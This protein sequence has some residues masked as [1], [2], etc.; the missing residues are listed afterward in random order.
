MEVAWLEDA[1][2]DIRDIQAYIAADGPRATE[3]MVRRLQEAVVLL[4]ET[5]LIGRR[6]RWPGTRELIVPGTRYIV[7]YRIRA[8]VIEIL[9]V[10][11]GARRWPEQTG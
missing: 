9:R 5:P 7:P 11:H 3:R 1:L 8:N 10:M 6:G 4:A 2:T